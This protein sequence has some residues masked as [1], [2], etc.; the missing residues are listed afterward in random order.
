MFEIAAGM[1]FSGCEIFPKQD[2]ILADRG[3]VGNFI[4]LPYF[5]SDKTVRYA[6][7][8]KGKD[9]SVEQFV[10]QAEKKQIT[11]YDLNKIDFGTRREEFSDARHVFRVFKLGCATRFEEHSSI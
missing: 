11:L 10:K 7:D 2:Q 9:L 1:G 5:D 4:N 3:D 8:E 6:V